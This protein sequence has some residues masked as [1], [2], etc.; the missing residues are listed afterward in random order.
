MRVVVESSERLVT[1]AGLGGGGVTTREG[2]IGKR[3]SW[4]QRWV[5]FELV[6]EGAVPLSVTV[7]IPIAWC[8]LGFLDRSRHLWG[9][10]SL[11]DSISGPFPVFEKGQ[12][13]GWRMGW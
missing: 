7:L 4:E 10:S 1:L 13:R 5:E 2:V 12:P 8:R 6:V 11:P 3:V 9:G